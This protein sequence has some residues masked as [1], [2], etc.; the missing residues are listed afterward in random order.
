M[1]Q[2]I[3]FSW[4]SDTDD[5]VGR[6][7]IEACMKAAIKVVKA[8]ADLD[9]ADRELKVD[10]DTRDVPGLPP[11]LDTIFLKIDRAAA[12]LSDLTYVATRKNGDLVP[13]SNVCIEH[14]YALKARTW[15]R[16][17]A[18]MNTAFG[19]PDDHELPFDLKHVRRPICFHLPEGAESPSSNRIEKRKP[20]LWFGQS[21]AG[22]T[23]VFAVDTRSPHD[24]ASRMNLPM[25]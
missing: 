14:G 2:H 4:Q 1:A 6:Y 18:V 10:R 13:N 5:D 25:F 23:V 22:S 17:I 15:R 11:I 20:F 12:F 21:F 19:S 8:D 3:F 24:G 7:F 9:P 16:M